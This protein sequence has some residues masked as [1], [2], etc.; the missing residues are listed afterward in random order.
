[1]KNSLSERRSKKHSP[2]TIGPVDLISARRIS[3]KIGGFA[4]KRLPA[5]AESLAGSQSRWP[6]KSGR[7]RLNLLSNDQFFEK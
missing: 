7:N 5:G 2:L 4:V 6:T 3:R 1:M